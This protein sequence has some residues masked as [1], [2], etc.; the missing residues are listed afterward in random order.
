L[1]LVYDQLSQDKTSV[2]QGVGVVYGAG[3]L[4]KTQLAVEYVHRFNQ[5]YPGGVL[6]VEA[7]Q[8]L[9]RLIDVVSRTTKVEVDGRLP[10]A[11]QLGEIWTGLA[12]RSAI[13]LV[14]DNFPEAG[15]LEPWLPPSGHIHT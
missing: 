11:D 15:P 13:L 12:R 2:V 4:G 10:D 1:W 8:G 9:P 14:L 6:W 5:H 3:G 7:D